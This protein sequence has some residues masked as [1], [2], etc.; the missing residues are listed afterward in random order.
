MANGVG[1]TPR[2]R[3]RPRLLVWGLACLLVAAGVTAVVLSPGDDPIASDDQGFSP[4][5]KTV[6]DRNSMC[7]GKDEFEPRNYIDH[8]DAFDCREL[9][10][11]EDAQAVL[12]L[13]PKDPNRFDPDRD[14]IACPELA[15]PKD[16]EVVSASAKRFRCRS[17]SRRSARCPQAAR[18]FH[19]QDYLYSGS[20][21]FDCS[22]FASQAD[23][24]AVLRYQPGDPNKLDGGNGIACPG[25]GP[26]KDLKPVATGPPS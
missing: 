23:A 8:G 12:R 4:L 10:R 24:Q 9:A 17:S 26:P 7:P 21:E 1:G 16:L 22:A 6:A 3:R 5:C 11:Q 20:D 13:D 14:G 18:K 25:L 19:V 2:P 15:G